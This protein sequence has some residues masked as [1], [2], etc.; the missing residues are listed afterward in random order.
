MMQQGQGDTH[1]KRDKHS[2]GPGAATSTPWD[3]SPA[4]K[5]EHGD[6]TAATLLY[7]LA[8]GGTCY[9]GRA[10]VTQGKYHIPA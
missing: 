4:T 5:K 1:Y 6:Q 2:K 9:L 7:P 8:R 3:H 10:S